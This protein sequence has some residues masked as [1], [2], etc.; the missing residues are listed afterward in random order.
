[1][2]TT[3]A[4]TIVDTLQTIVVTPVRKTTILNMNI[5]LKQS[6]LLVCATVAFFAI[7]TLYAI[8]ESI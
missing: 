2:H 5:K 4:I 3:Y 7:A 8:I 1:L 6:E